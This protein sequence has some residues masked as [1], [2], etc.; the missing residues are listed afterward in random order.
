MNNKKS[1]VLTIFLT[2]VF[3]SA[4]YVGVHLYTPML[5]NAL[6]NAVSFL[7]PGFGSEGKM[8]EIRSII[9]KNY[10][11]EPNADKLEA[12]A[13]KGYVAGLE[14][15]YG[16]Y[17][18]AEEY[19]SMTAQLSGNYK[20]IGVEVTIGDNNLITI[21]AAYEGAPAAKA[22]LM[23][24]DCI[25]KVNDT[26]VN[27]DNYNKAIDM[28]KGVGEYGKA[29]D[30]TLTIKRGEETFKVDITREE[31]SVDTV[32]SEMLKGNIGYVSLSQFA[33]ESDEDFEIAVNELISSGA[34]SLIIDLRDNPGGMLTTV[35][36]VADYLLPKGNILTIK[37]RNS[38]PQEF[39]SDEDCIDLPMCVIIN[40]NSASASEVLA[41]ALKDHQ[42]AILVGETSF[43]KG[44]VQ[45]IYD[46]SDKSALKITTAKYYTPNDT[47]IDGKG[48]KPDHE[49]KMELT[50]PLSSYTKDEDT[51]LQKAI[52][53]LK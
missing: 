7:T 5:S 26:K 47:C 13:L 44:V 9:E 46:L 27:G 16:E 51:Q 1:T 45:S 42:K 32:D 53:L 49:V 39:S 12:K 35:V 33:D 40:G 50:K 3:T 28:M 31:V 43:G 10:I 4:L 2:F 15:P 29:D 17:Y 36:N 14:D 19:A 22:G 30:M 8:S 38:I 41:G 6:N 34:K 48:I 11:E 37:G 20:G 52:E 23:P 18:T 24:G 21:L 25:I